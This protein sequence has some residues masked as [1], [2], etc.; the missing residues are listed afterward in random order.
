VSIASQ[1]E[2]AVTEFFQRQASAFRLDASALRV[3]YVLNWGGFVNHSFQVSDGR[4]RLHLKLATSKAAQNALRRWH[5]HSATLQQYHAPPVL[6]WIDLTGAS[7]L[8]FPHMDGITP[9]L[10]DDVVREVT[11][12]LDRLHHDRD[13]RA[14]LMPNTRPTAADTYFDIYHA[15]FVGDLELI[16]ASRPRFVTEAVLEFMEHEVSF[17]AERVRSSV[18]FQ[19]P[20]DT[21]IHGDLWLNNILWETRD[22]WHLLDWDD[23]CIGDPAIDIA[24]LTGP[25]PDALAPLK[26]VEQLPIALSDS[27]RQRLLLYG[28]ASLLDWIIDPIADWIE[29]AAAPALASESRPEKERIHRQALEVYGPLFTY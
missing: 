3:S 21:P 12:V 13:L 24:M 2:T 19:E 17:L 28:R 16:R 5:Q 9:P 7:G 15:R 8:V 20:L 1:L 26:G 14:A 10:S 6:R 22:S 4:T 29:A 27:Q 18:E 25:T 11:N 23:M